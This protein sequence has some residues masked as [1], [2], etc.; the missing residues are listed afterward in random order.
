[1]YCDLKPDDDP[2]LVGLHT[3]LHLFPL[4][5]LQAND[6]DL[7][8]LLRF[9]LSRAVESTELL[10]ELLDLVALTERLRLDAWVG[11]VGG[12]TCPG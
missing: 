12:H 3:L 5:I 8:V 7:H 6:P 4:P 2:P 9:G 1:M 10:H 11:E